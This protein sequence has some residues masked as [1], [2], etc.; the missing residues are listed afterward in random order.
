M[1]P[2]NYML[3][4]THHAIRHKNWEQMEVFHLSPGQPK[5]LR[6][7]N[8][9]P[10]C[11]LKDIALNCDIE[12]AT[13]SKMVNALEDKGMLQRSI[14]PS[15]K[16]AYQLNITELGIQSLKKWNKHCLEIENIALD[17][18]DS[19]DKE[20]LRN[21]LSRIYTNLTGKEID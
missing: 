17:G 2:L 21:Y 11:K 7:L 16:R 14:D 19:E 10:N 4:K 13:A 18:F 1:E 3:F 9:H 8:N 15:N 12:N 6:Y 5:V 20:Q